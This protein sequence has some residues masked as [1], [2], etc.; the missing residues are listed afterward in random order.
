MT[1]VWASETVAGAVDV[2]P[3][4]VFALWHGR[5]INWIGPR[6]TPSRS[7]GRTGGSWSQ[8]VGLPRHRMQTGLAGSQALLRAFRSGEWYHPLAPDALLVR[9]GR[10]RVS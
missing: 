4:I 7:C 3:V 2:G 1:G 6:S 8:I 5:H 9:R 10:L